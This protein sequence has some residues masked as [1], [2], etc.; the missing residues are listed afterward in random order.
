M[1]RLSRSAPRTNTGAQLIA[2]TK[3]KVPQDDKETSDSI[4]R[5]C[6]CTLDELD[7]KMAEM[8]EIPFKD[9]ND[10]QWGLYNSAFRILDRKLEIQ[11]LEEDSFDELEGLIDELEGLGVNQTLRGLDTLC[12]ARTALANKKRRQEEET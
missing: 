1:S 4:K 3:G 11:E 2:G 10:R 9:F 6:Q 5:F 8:R 7:D 12:N